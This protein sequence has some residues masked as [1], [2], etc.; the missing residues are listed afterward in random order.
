MRARDYRRENSRFT[1]L[2]FPA[3]SVLDPVRLRERWSPWLHLTASDEA[4]LRARHALQLI[5]ML[6][7]KQD[8]VVPNWFSIVAPAG[9]RLQ[10]I[11]QA[12][13]DGHQ[14]DRP[15]QLPPAQRTAAWQ[16]L[17]DNLD[18]WAEQSTARRIILV[19]LLTQ[20]GFHRRAVEL[21]PRMSSDIEDVLGQQLAYEV[22]RAAFELNRRSTVPLRIL[23]WLAEH[24]ANPALRVLAALRVVSTMARVHRD[25]A[26]ADLWLDRAGGEAEELGAEPDWLRHLTVSRYHRAAA[27][28]RVSGRDL[29][30]ATE[31][32]GAALRHDEQLAAVATDPLVQHYQR[33]NRQLVLEA[34]L[35]LDTMT[36]S[37]CAPGDAA[38]QAQLL[39]PDQDLLFVLGEHRAGREE[40]QGAQEMFWAAAQLGTVHGAVAALC[41]G[42]CRE[43]LGRR[44]QAVT[45]YRLCLDLDPASLSGAE[46]LA[47]VSPATA[48]HA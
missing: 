38:E 43:R 32:L 17:V 9:S 21:V 48:L 2:D 20:L 35:K 29:A 26:G 5:G 39:H 33:E 16:A 19:E 34:C 47:A 27:L 18:R 44:D 1:D 4:P 22:A 31:H 12:R 25:Q 6:T 45:A 10:I 36:G 14:G 40:W 11:R 7:G 41:A 3:P 46:R 30:G 23:E 28:C 24:A 8:L 37:A 13:L 42:E 15:E